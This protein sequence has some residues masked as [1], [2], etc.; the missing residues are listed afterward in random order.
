[1]AADAQTDKAEEA[2]KLIEY[3]GS[4]EAQQRQLT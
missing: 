1:M 2:W 3:L 4:E